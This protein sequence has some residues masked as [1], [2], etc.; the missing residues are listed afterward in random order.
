MLDLIFAVLLLALVLIAI[1]LRKSYHALP[2]KELKHRI[3]YGDKLA[4]KLY[5]AAAYGQT[6]DVFLWMVIII[7]TAVSLVLLTQIVPLLLSIV[8]VALVMW[9]AFAWL[10]KTRVSKASDQIVSWFTPAVASLLN[11]LN[12]LVLRYHS[13]TKT[14]S[15]KPSHSGIYDKAGLNELLKKQKAQDDNRIS[16]EQLEKLKD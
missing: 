8:L 2:P 6:L 14:S 12:P 9:L 15:E 7:G 10:P 4:E 5:R 3:R 13:L 11:Y 1:D 16:K